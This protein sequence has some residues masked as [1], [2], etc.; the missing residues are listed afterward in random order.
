M[1]RENLTLEFGFPLY[2]ITETKRCNGV[3]ERINRN[4]SSPSAHKKKSYLLYNRLA[5][6]NLKL[7]YNEDISINRWKTL[8]KARITRKSTLKSCK[9]KHETIWS[10]SSPLHAQQWYSLMLL[11]SSFWHLKQKKQNNYF[12]SVVTTTS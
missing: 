4:Y 7:I 3:L 9:Y 10:F 2:Q 8:V 5:K 11:S 6:P 12:H 1:E